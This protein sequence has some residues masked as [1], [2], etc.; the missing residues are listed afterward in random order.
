[1]Q[2][3]LSLALAGALCLPLPN[4]TAIARATENEPLKVVTTFSVLKYF[5]Q[6]IGGDR[7]D[8]YSLCDPSEDPSTYQPRLA[9]IERVHAADVL[10]E[11][12]AE[13]DPLEAWLPKLVESA[14]STRL[15]TGKPGR[16]VAAAGISRPAR[17]NDINAPVPA[18]SPCLWLDPL[19]ARDMATN[20]AQSLVKIDAA[21]AA[22]FEARLK[23]LQEK[24]DAA[25]FGE[26]LV[27][28]VGTRTLLQKAREGTLADFLETRGL[29]E[30]LGGWLR[31][32]LPLKGRTVTTYRGT[33]T[34][35]A[36]RFGLQAPM[37][38]ETK[39]SVPPTT[40]RR[41][42]LE[43]SMKARSVKT[44]LREVYD[45]RLTAKAL[46]EATGAHVVVI[47]SDVGPN[48]GVSSY[49]D[50]IDHCID[51]ILDSEEIEASRK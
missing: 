23:K 11:V 28:D 19:L 34:C 15:R 45:D 20:I 5:A 14:D 26:A 50:L 10:I 8:A 47:S 39:R 49:F 46:A 37:E 42:E 13:S 41:D 32:A 9:A 40:Q 44:I 4:A 38:I 25:L 17:V 6:E 22:I 36:D 7:V 31:R 43:A 51:R 18:G 33:W 21:H 2:G 30:K 12:G 3:F 27:K 48:V 29:N 35:F 1:M 24:F 16:I